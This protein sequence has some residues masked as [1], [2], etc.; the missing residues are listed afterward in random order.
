MHRMQD[1]PL[2]ELKTNLS[3]ILPGKRSSGRGNWFL[4][5]I[6]TV[7]L[8]YWN[9]SLVLAT[10]VGVAVMLLVQQMHERKITLPWL[11]IREFLKRWNQPVVLAVS[12]GAIATLT[13]YLS[14]SIWIESESSWIALGSILQ[15]MGT[16]AVLVLLAWLVLEQQSNRDRSVSN[17]CLADLTDA[18]PLK[19]LIA[20]RQLISTA[21]TLRDD[22]EQRQAIADYFHLMLNQEKEPIVQEAILEG[23]QMLH[24]VRQ[25]KSSPQPSVNSSQMKR[26]TYRQRDRVA[27]RDPGQ[28]KNRGIVRSPAGSQAATLPTHIRQ[29]NDPIQR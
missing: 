26:Q 19:R 14:A 20:V 11:A 7:T 28:S 12:A 13:T 10:G 18:D 3:K 17:Q 8:L 2:A 27:V 6:G 25:L 22:P 29:P 5:T 9:G 16:L 23:L 21:P 24:R 1:I 15:G 4:A